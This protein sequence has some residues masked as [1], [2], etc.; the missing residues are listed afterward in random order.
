MST[1]KSKPKT[2]LVNKEKKLIKIC[3]LTP[4]RKRSYL[5][6]KALGFV[7]GRFWEVLFAKTSTYQGQF[8][9]KF[10]RLILLRQ[11]LAGMELF[12]TQFTTPAT[13]RWLFQGWHQAIHVIASIAIVTKQQLVVIVAGATNG[14]VF[15]LDALPAILFHRDLHVG[16]EL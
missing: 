4:S 9:F 1:F 15:A 2:S 16:S 6:G 10:A 3:H 11:L 5:A 12:G 13:L 14:A 7:V 8:R